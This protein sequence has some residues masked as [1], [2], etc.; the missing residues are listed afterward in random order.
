MEAFSVI[1]LV[2]GVLQIVLLFW[3]ISTLN[4]IKTNT[5]EFVEILEKNHEELVYTIRKAVVDI[6]GKAEQ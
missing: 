4:A 3:F 2:M 1:V 6:R 5:A